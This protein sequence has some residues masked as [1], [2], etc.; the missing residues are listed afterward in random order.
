[1]RQKTSR[2]KMQLRCRREREE[3]FLRMDTGTDQQEEKK[4]KTTTGSERS[5]REE[6]TAGEW[7]SPA[8]G[9]SSVGRNLGA[10]SCAQAGS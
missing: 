5:L 7:E 9:S 2:M 3:K 6:E 4:P 1:M 10:S 8:C